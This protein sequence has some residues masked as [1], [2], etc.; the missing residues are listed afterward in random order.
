[1]TEVSKSASEPNAAVRETEIGGD[2]SVGEEADGQVGIEDDEHAFDSSEQGSIA[3]SL[4]PFDDSL[5]DSEM[6]QLV[7]GRNRDMGVCTACQDLFASICTVG[8]DREGGQPVGLF[9]N[10]M[11]GDDRFLHRIPEK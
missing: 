1:M 10:D 3:S 9:G 8:P 6:I 4:G 7:K 5:L 2:R 11:T